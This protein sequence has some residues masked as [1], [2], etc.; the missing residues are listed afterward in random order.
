MLTKD[1]LLLFM[2]ACYLTPIIIVYYNYN[3]NSSVSNIICNENNKNI[4][5]FFMLLM[6]GGTIL[7]EFERNDNIS[8]ILICFLLIGIYGLVCIYDNRAN[9]R[10][11]IHYIFAFLVFIT[12]LC[13]MIRHSYNIY[14][15]LLSF[16]LL[17][18]I[19]AL[20]FIIVTLTENDTRFFWGEIFYILNFAFFFIYLHF[21]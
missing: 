16:S 2:L 10:N 1:C 19:I 15:N 14:S 5:L 13:F 21:L 12:I 18:E 4:I 8:I 20:L 9:A 3:S 17:L 11:Y 6:G 7:Y